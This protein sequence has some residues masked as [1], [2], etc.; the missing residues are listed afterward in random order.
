[1]QFRKQIS[2]AREQMVEAAQA[3]IRIPSV[4]AEPQGDM[5]FGKGMNE[6]LVYV[7]RLAEKLGLPV[8]NLDGYCGYAEVGEGELY[9]GIFS[10][11]DVYAEESSTWK[12]GLYDGEIEDNKIYGNGAL[13]KG[14]LVAALFGLKAVKDLGIPLRKK[15]R[16][17][18]GTDEGKRY[19]DIARYLS[20][21][22]PPLAGFT[23]DGYFPVVY[24]EKGIAMLEYEKKIPQDSE[25]FVEYIRGGVSE[26]IVPGYC[27]A[28]LRTSRRSELVASLTSY[29]RENR[30]DLNAKIL[31][32][33]VLIESFGVEFHCMA[34]EKGLNSVAQMIDFLDSV[35]FGSPTL[36]ETL[37]F[38]NDAIG[39]E[40]YGESLG[41][42][43][44]D[45]FSGRLTFNIGL[46]KFEKG[47]MHLRCDCRFPI[48][49][50]FEQTTRTLREKFSGAGFT[51]T[52]YRYWNPTYLPRNHFLIE[53]LLDVYRRVTRDDSE[54][55]V[56]SCISYAT[57]MPNVA[58]FGAI[59]PGEREIN[60][61]ANEYIDIDKML[62]ASEIY[63]EAAY[64]LATEL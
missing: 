15:I 40:I 12:Y 51:E 14:A 44:E 3:L 29:A 58:A 57:E 25:E 48:I 62:L 16:F 64:R 37:H 20:E 4:Q 17:F 9:V 55:L 43:Q 18:V 8:K 42:A 53:T 45:N 38:L 34:I 24:A 33:G 35:R 46:F 52:E 47:K 13:D 63:A 7:L 28:K 54:P 32:D 5:P 23:T 2:E 39:F 10:H 22:K 19:A 50:N 6:A 26:N 31:E 60:Y 59:F 49:C 21:E 56:S 30:K 11:V 36:Q 27:R 61:Q 41:I 1:M